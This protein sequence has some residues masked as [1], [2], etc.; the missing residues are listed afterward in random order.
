MHTL[1]KE[2]FGSQT[3]RSPEPPEVHKTIKLFGRLDQGISEKIVKLY[4]KGLSFSEIRT[5][6]GKAK[7]TIQATLKKAGIERRPNLSRSVTSHWST[8][9]KSNI[10]PPYGFCY[11]QGKVVADPREYEN[12]LLIHRLWKELVNPNSIADRLNAK[13]IAPR[14][15]SAWNRNSVVN[16]IKRFETK[17]IILKGDKYELR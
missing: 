15:A 3:R 12:L 10:R 5:Q 6:T 2:E 14:S 7:S 8:P 9:G 1:K 17:T 16:I 4:Q 13:K 11:F